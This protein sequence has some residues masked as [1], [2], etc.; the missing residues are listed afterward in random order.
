MQPTSCIFLVLSYQV[1]RPNSSLSLI[2]PELTKLLTTLITLKLIN[3]LITSIH[4]Y[5]SYFWRTLCSFISTVHNAHVT[6]IETEWRHVAKKWATWR[7]DIWVLVE[8]NWNIIARPIIFKLW[9][10]R[11]VAEKIWNLMMPIWPMDLA[12]QSLVY[13]CIVAHSWMRNRSKVYMTWEHSKNV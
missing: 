1:P 2:A 12:K 6:T 7:K 11:N 8:I 10:V 3:L 4:K 5:R 13:G 9:S